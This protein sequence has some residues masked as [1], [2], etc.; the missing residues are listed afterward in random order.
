MSSFKIKLNGVDIDTIEQ[1]KANFSAD[2]LRVFKNQEIHDWFASRKMFDEMNICWSIE[3]SFGD[4][5]ILVEIAKL[6]DLP[7]DINNAKTLLGLSKPKKEDL[8][9]EYKPASE[10]SLVE[11]TLSTKETVQHSLNDNS[12]NS[13]Y[14]IAGTPN[15][16]KKSPNP[17]QEVHQPKEEPKPQKPIQT[18]SAY[19]PQPLL[20]NVPQFLTEEE[21]FNIEGVRLANVTKQNEVTYRPMQPYAPTVK[22]T[23]PELII[24][25]PK[26][27]MNVLV[28]AVFVKK[29]QKV[30]KRDK[31]IEYYFRDKYYYILSPA[32]GLVNELY[33]TPEAINKIRGS[34]TLIDLTFRPILTLKVDKIPRAIRNNAVQ[35]VA[36]LTYE[37]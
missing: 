2:I 3:Q 8:S 30:R 1:L 31:L 37:F 13:N 16:S 10:K 12:Y 14:Y 22:P 26:V 23:F 25:M 24:T 9:K 19:I 18:P 15:Y 27:D 4:A 21:V 11:Q 5:Q 17:Q 28:L 7:L 33:F 20:T 36:K 34:M 35:G 6:I 29:N 32:D